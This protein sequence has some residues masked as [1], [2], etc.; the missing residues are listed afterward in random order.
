[1]INSR[2][3]VSGMKIGVTLNSNST[4]TSSGVYNRSCAVLGFIS[5]I[6]SLN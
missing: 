6:E 5:L 3:F 4:V 1:M 2:E